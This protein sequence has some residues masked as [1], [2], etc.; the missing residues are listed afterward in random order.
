MTNQEKTQ[1][2]IR[3]IIAT[4]PDGIN[5]RVCLYES[6]AIELAARLDLMI[7]C[8]MHIPVA[9]KD[10]LKADFQVVL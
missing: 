3:Q 10:R 6:I 5:E 4:Y 7:D 1:E 2:A 9:T 8:A